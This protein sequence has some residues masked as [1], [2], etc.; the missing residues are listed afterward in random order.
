MQYLRV[1]EYEID[2]CPLLLNRYE[3]GIIFEIVQDVSLLQLLLM[4]VSCS[5]VRLNCLY[6]EQ[7]VGYCSTLRSTIAI[8]VLPAQLIILELLIKVSPGKPAKV[9]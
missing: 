2:T 8:V 3:F 4:R 9:M 5:S 7:V 6:S 1:H